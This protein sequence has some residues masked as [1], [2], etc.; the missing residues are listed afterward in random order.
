[1]SKHVSCADCGDRVSAFY[2]EDGE[3]LCHDCADGDG[4]HTDLYCVHCGVE[5]ETGME[6]DTGVCDQ[7]ADAYAPTGGDADE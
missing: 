2:Y 6:H 4:L 7:C 5:L 1:M 3:R